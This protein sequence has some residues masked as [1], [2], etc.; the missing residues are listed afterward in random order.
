MS[1]PLS[2]KEH[3]SCVYSIGDC[4]SN[5]CK[6]LYF[7]RIKKHKYT[8]LISDYDCFLTIATFLSWPRNVLFLN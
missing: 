4:Q 3:K 7:V 1:H 8:T 5:D 6:R 2:L